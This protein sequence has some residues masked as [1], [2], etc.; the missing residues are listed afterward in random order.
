MPLEIVFLRPQ[1]WSRLKPNHSSTI[2][3][4]KVKFRKRVVM[5]RYVL[6][7]KTN[8]LPDINVVI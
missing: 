1:N 2:T 3:A 5:C 8:S 4:V 6:H 7:R